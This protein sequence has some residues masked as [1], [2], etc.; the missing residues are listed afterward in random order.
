MT[1]IRMSQCIKFLVYYGSCGKQ[2]WWTIWDERDEKLA[3]DKMQRVLSAT[4]A[5]G[6]EVEILKDDQL[7]GKTNSVPNNLHL[8]VHTL[9]SC[10]SQAL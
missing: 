8:V 3:I 4:G 7:S 6:G 5:H 2:F 9:T 1:P 10:S